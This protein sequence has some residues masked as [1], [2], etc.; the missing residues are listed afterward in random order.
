MLVLISQPGSSSCWYCCSDV[1]ISQPGCWYCC[2]DVGFAGAM[3]AS[4]IIWESESSLLDVIRLWPIRSYRMFMFFLSPFPRPSFGL[5]SFLSPF[6]LFTRNMF[7]NP[8]NPTESQSPTRKMKPIL[9]SLPPEEQQQYKTAPII[10]YCNNNK[11]SGIIL[12]GS[13]TKSYFLRRFGFR[14]FCRSLRRSGSRGANTIRIRS[15]PCPTRIGRPTTSRW[16]PT[17]TPP[18]RRS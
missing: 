2:S 9:K 6:R 16:L 14:R 11:T 7:P 1:L 17:C 5:F 8:R 13:W 3:D 18:H 4:T 12:A 15:A 10:M